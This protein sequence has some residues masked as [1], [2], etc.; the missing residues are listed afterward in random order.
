VPRAH[1][2]AARCC[3]SRA[4]P[5]PMTLT[6]MHPVLLI[7]IRAGSQPLWML[8]QRLSRPTAPR[9]LTVSGSTWC[10]ESPRCS[11]CCCCC[12]QR[13]ACVTLSAFSP[14]P[15]KHSSPASAAVALCRLLLL[16]LFAYSCVVDCMT[17]D[18]HTQSCS[19]TYMVPFV[20]YQHH[21]HCHNEISELRC[22]LHVPCLDCF[23]YFAA[24]RLGDVGMWHF[25]LHGF[26][27]DFLL[28]Q[29]VL[30]WSCLTAVILS[31]C[32]AQCLPDWCCCAHG[33]MCPAEPA[34]NVRQ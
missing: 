23:P 31:L 21:T 20:V 22:C 30:C 33:I 14:H 29:R 5:L 19:R 28:D 18:L 9:A 25:R 4:V 13:H 11:S 32:S 15:R 10:F 2:S 17:A 1:H 8:C 12:C 34:D 7:A 16:G 27:N 6:R 3:S 26:R 24:C